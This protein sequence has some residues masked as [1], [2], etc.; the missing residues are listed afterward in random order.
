M[1]SSRHAAPHEL[2]ALML[3]RPLRLVSNALMIL[4][5]LVLL[6]VLP[7][8]LRGPAPTSAAR[9]TRVQPEQQAALP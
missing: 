9:A 7:T 5:L 6:L 8:I 1:H 3:P 4:C 2:D